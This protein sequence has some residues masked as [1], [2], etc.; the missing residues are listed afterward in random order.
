MLTGTGVK[1]CGSWWEV[2]GMGRDGGRKPTLLKVPDH[3]VCVRKHEGTNALCIKA[4]SELMLSTPSLQ[5]EQHL[6]QFAEDNLYISRSDGG[7]AAA[8]HGSSQAQ[9][10][11]GW[12][13]GSALPAAS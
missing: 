8:G 1:L 11:E 5:R 9:G 6:T 12:W 3:H 7:R 2:A 10:W 13:Q 4:L